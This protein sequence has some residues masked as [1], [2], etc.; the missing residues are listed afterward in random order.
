MLNPQAVRI[1]IENL[2]L[3]NP[4]LVGEID[5]WMLSL[6]SETSFNELMLSIVRKIEDTTALVVGTKDRLDALKA[7]KD[8]FEH[9]VE[10]LRDLAFKMME[11]AELAKLA[12]VRQQAHIRV[13]HKAWAKTILANNDAGHRINPT[14][15]LFA[16]QAMRE[17]L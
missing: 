7:R 11:A 8:R 9:R 12:P 6:E 3:T 14:S 15:L 5:D 1:Q 10:S 2:R 16:K 17:A 13:D 4:E